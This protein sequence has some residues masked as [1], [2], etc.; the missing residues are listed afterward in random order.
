MYFEFL[1]TL[2]YIEKVMLNECNKHSDCYECPF[3][4][5]SNC[6]REQF[7]EIRKLTAAAFGETYVKED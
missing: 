6:N 4:I 7:E 1:N 5:C 2:E 3:I